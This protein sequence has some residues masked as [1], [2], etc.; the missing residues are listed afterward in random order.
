MDLLRFHAGSRWNDVS[1]VSPIAPSYVRAAQKVGGAIAIREKQKD[2]KWVPVAER[3]NASFTPTVFECTGRRSELTK[4]LFKELA[5]SAAEITEEDV[6]TA[7]RKDTFISRVVD[8]ITQHVSVAMAHCNALL[9]EEAEHLAQY[10]E[11]PKKLAKR[12]FVHGN[13]NYKLF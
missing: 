6:S 8:E 2:K 9:L 13:P 11:R 12:A 3:R 7:N 5:T 1:V 4:A 10:K